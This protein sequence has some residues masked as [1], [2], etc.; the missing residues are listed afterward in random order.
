MFS[1]NNAVLYQCTLLK[2]STYYL[3]NMYF[4]L[5]C[6]VDCAI[7]TP[8]VSSSEKTPPP[9][10]TR[11]LTETNAAAEE[12]HSCGATQPGRHLTI[13]KKHTHTHR[14]RKTHVCKHK[15]SAWGLSHPDL[16][17]QKTSC[18]HSWWGHWLTAAPT[19]ADVTHNP[20]SSEQT[21]FVVSTVLMSCAKC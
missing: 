12:V 11:C 4:V 16:H 19:D 18:L 6:T 8:S 7:G 17:I 10:R 2:N 5:F 21:L 20:L 15:S 3:S 13:R 9:D 14:E 1:L